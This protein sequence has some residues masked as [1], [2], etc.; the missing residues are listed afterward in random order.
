MHL[1]E[2]GLPSDVLVWHA[3]LLTVISFGVGVLGGFV[4]LALGTVRLPAL[5]LMGISPPVAAGTNIAVSTASALVGAVRHYR[6]GRVD[7]RTVLV[8]GV[9]GMV[10]AFI[11]GFSS[12]RAPE[13]LLILAVGILVVW[14]G[15]ELVA[16]ARKHRAAG[17]R[18]QA[19]VA[20]RPAGPGLP[21]RREIGGAGVGLAVGV[22]GGAVGLILGSIRLPAM[23][24]ILRLDPRSA[25]GTNLF[26]GFAMGSMGWIGHVSR[27]QVDY[28]LV[29]LMGTTAMAGSYLG[30]RLT[31]RVSLDRLVMTMGLVLLAV[32][33]LLLWR[34]VAA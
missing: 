23:I 7:M 10:G 32:G 33:A 13:S 31:G 17:P 2:L 9:P 6:G 14:Q 8:M 21:H 20:G 22:I 25:A 1:D 29:A 11:G 30:A 4:G 16:R 34:A 18:A 19:D 15:V 3:A 26:I 28:P 24:R 5:L 12:G 27:G